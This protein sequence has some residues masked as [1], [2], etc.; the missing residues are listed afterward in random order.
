ML[1][2]KFLT[3]L[4]QRVLESFFIGMI[5][6]AVFPIIYFRYLTRTRR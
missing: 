5:I 1:V 6:F 4:G 2:E 3:F